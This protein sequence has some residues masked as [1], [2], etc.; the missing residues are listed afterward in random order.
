MLL[1]LRILARQFLRRGSTR[2]LRRLQA[3]LT[4]PGDCVRWSLI[5][6]SIAVL[7]IPTRPLMWAAQRGTAPTPIRDT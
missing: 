1:S 5:L 2:I 7:G 6:L 4:I 3:G